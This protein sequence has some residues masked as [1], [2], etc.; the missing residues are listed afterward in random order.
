MDLIYS[1]RILR[2]AE[3]VLVGLDVPV[4][5]R[6]T[7]AI[8]GLAQSPRP[9]GAVKMAGQELWRIRVGD[10]R[11]IYSIHDREIVVLITRI[12]HRREVYRDP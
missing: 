11:V 6:L 9:P 7:E 1:I 3:K 4:Q 8:R 10:Y 2:S 5:K 12:G